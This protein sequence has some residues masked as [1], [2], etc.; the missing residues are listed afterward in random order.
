MA[1]PKVSFIRRFHCGPPRDNP[2]C[3]N[4]GLS[5]FFFCSKQVSSKQKTL[6]SWFPKPKVDSSGLGAE[7]ESEG[8]C[9]AAKRPKLDGQ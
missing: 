3:C 6:F 7:G 9:A 8:V 2:A 1:G 4:C 5:T